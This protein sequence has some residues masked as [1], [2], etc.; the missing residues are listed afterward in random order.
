M[1]MKIIL[2]KDSHLKRSSIRNVVFDALRVQFGSFFYPLVFEGWEAIDFQNLQLTFL[3]VAFLSVLV[4]TQVKTKKLKRQYPL[5]WS[6]LLVEFVSLFGQSMVSLINNLEQTYHLKIEIAVFM[7]FV[8]MHLTLG[9]EWLEDII[10]RD[11]N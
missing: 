5:L 4:N 6:I 3:Q 7:I 11:M 8:E 1:V 9:F 10:F 2:N